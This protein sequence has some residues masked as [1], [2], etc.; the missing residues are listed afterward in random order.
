M[1]DIEITAYGDDCLIRAHV[2]LPAEVR[3][4]DHLNQQESVALSRVQLLSLDDAH[5]VNLDTLELAM[6]DILA[7]EAPA[8]A[9]TGS[10]KIRTRTS[11]IEVELGPYRVLG[12]LHGPTTSDP[13]V[14]I[15][16]RKPMVPITESTIAFNLAG[17][18]RMRDVDV[19]IV[20]RLR[21]SL[22][23]RVAVEE[24]KL[25]QFTRTV[26]V[27][28]HSKDLTSELSYGIRDP[29]EER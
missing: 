16:R 17:N 26:T 22:V 13:F 11:R 8:L 27:D 18:A 15:T 24:D 1:A 2:E 5:V 23:Q 25:D 6:D 28:P 7:V 19:V 12:H 29:N 14:A 4:S 20:N 21:A 9:T 10:H 3:L